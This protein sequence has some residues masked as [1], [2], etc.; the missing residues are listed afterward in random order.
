[1][2]KFDILAQENEALEHFNTGWLWMR[3]GEVVADA[4][5][6][7]LVAD[8]HVQSRDQV[9]FNEVSCKDVFSADRKLPTAPDRPFDM[10]PGLGYKGAANGPR[11]DRLTLTNRVHGAQRAAGENT[12]SIAVSSVPP[13]GSHPPESS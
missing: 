4:W 5:R 3:R 2:E 12:R 6:A 10:Q 11:L 7:V 13:R 8:L 9:F 1:M